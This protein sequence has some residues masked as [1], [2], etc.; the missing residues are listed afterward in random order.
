MNRKK[1]KSAFRAVTAGALTAAMLLS[2]GCGRPQNAQ[3]QGGT[4]YVITKQQLHYWDEVK[5]GAEDACEELGYDI[6]YSTATGDNDYSTQKQEI[7][8]AI[9]NNAD[10]IVIA[11][12]SSSDLNE[13]IQKAKDSGIKVVAINSTFDSLNPLVPLADSFVNSSDSEGG[14]SAARNALEKW[15]KDR[16]KDIDDIGKVGIIM[17]TAST[18][19]TRKESFI[20]TMKR[21]IGA[22]M[23]VDFPVI[24]AMAMMGGGDYG[25]EGG[26]DYGEGGG[27]YAA[28]NGEYTVAEEADPAAAAAEA[29]PEVEL[30][31]AER[32]ALEKQKAQEAAD[33]RIRENI[34]KHFQL[35]DKC[36]DREKAKQEAL[37]MIGTDG[38]GFSIIFA[39]NTNTTLGLC[40][41]IA[42][43]G[44]TGKILVIGFNADPDEITLLRAG[45]IDGLVVQN[46]YVMGYVGVKNAVKMCNGDQVTQHLNVG[47]NFID[48]DLLDDEFIKLI[49]NPNGAEE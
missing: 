36:G 7:Q 32:L 4:I 16:N 41:A 38:N 47:V 26:G 25:A 15:H 17:S 29:E 10:A 28:G 45:A 11:P 18:A 44:L 30:T 14:I 2:S 34:M 21:A 13:D 3:K 9:R 5:S 1:K 48:T 27:D 43:R 23:G 49:L 6:V 37:Q 24:N 40:D 22:K 20:D 39:T 46:P 31:D 12:N 33:E 35:T 42:E 19:E 8:K